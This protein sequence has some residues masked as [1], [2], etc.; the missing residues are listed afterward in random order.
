[1]Q[2]TQ[3]LLET[4]RTEGLSHV[5]LVPGGLIDP[6]LPALSSTPGIT[7][8]VAAHEGGAACMA[9][10]YAR[11]SGLFGA[12]FAIGGPGVTN[13]VTAILAACTDKSPVMVVSGQVPTDWEGRGGFHYQDSSPATLN[14]VD[15][16]RDITESSLIVES[17]H[18]FNHHLRASFTKMLAGPKGPVHISIP[19]D[20]QRG[21]HTRSLGKTR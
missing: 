17:A 21:R 11:A 1:M 6:F 15:L 7:P 16:F 4:F 3:Y 12:C 10:G 8:V 9:D 13:M 5:F 14:D 2:T 20:I 18:L 19:T